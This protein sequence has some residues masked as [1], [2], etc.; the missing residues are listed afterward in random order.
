M[1]DKGTL[2]WVYFSVL[3]ISDDVRLEQ[4]DSLNKLKAKRDDNAVK[5]TLENI[6]KAAKEGGNL[7][8]ERIIWDHGLGC[9]SRGCELNF[10]DTKQQGVSGV[11]PEAQD[12]FTEISGLL[13]DILVDAGQSGDSKLDFKL[14][15]ED[16]ELIMAEASVQAEQ[17]LKQK[18]PD[19]PTSMPKTVSNALEQALA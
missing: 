9:L 15:N 3:E 1:V 13:S 18:I 6:T 12:K 14:A 4:I 2:P 16:A 8:E 7:L 10:R 17:Q 5:Q 19:I 11:V